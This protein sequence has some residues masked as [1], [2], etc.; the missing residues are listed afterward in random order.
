PTVQIRYGAGIGIGFLLG[1]IVG[2]KQMCSAGTSVGD[3]DNP[4]ANGKCNDIPGTTTNKSK[5]PVVPIV[6]LLAGVRFKLID[7]LSLNI[8]VGT[9]ALPCAGANIGYFFYPRRRYSMTRTGVQVVP[10]SVV[11]SHRHTRAFAVMSVNTMRIWRVLPSIFFG[12]PTRIMS[13]PSIPPT[14][15][16]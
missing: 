10:P 2:T 15:V 16:R 1:N 8:E 4:T 3:L 12:S 5:P 13:F 14:N 6:H 11:R 7:Q 9:R